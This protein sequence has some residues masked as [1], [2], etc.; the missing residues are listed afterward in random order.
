[1]SSVYCNLRIGGEVIKRRGVYMNRES[2]KQSGKSTLLGYVW[3]ILAV[4]GIHT[5]LYQPYSIPSGSMMPTLLVG[6][7]LFVNKFSY[8]YS[9]YSA[10][11]Q[12][13]FIKGRINIG[14]PN[15]GD[16][17]VFFHEF[18][19]ENEAEHYDHGVLNGLFSRTWRRIRSAIGCPLEGV[20]Y[21][22]RVI[23]LPGDRIQMKEGK[24]YINGEEVKLEY[25]DTYPLNE[26]N[27]PPIAK[28]YIETLPNGVRHYI[29]KAFP[30]GK[31]HL[32][33][34]EEFVVPEGHYF[35]MGDNR[36]NS[37]DSRERN[38]VGDI[39]NGRFIGVPSFLYFSTEATLF[40]PHKW[41]FLIR[42]QRLFDAYI[43]KLRRPFQANLYV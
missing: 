27:M 14:T 2:D 28:R 9:R 19:Y 36:D 30:F 26:P 41:I 21:V 39:P 29:L 24:L 42:W 11:L 34:T 37:C 6:D 33:N 3:A 31:A 23:G 4:I 20:N 15:R 8:G 5:F 18:T 40:Q 1:M 22:K 43:K 12:P 13:K 38:I 25:V 17:A 32:D 16:V 7:F 35:M 10:F